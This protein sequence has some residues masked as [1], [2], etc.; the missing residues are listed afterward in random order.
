MTR[1][2]STNT[3]QENNTMKKYIVAAAAATALIAATAWA[4]NEA[5]TDKNAAVKELADLGAGVHKIK[6]DENNTLVSCVIVGQARISMS[7]GKAKGVMNAKKM[8]KQNAEAAFVGWL[9]K[10]VTDISQTGDTS[11]LHITGAD[12]NGEPIEDA[13]ST[14]TVSQI[15]TSQ[16]QGQI[17]AMQLIGMDQDGENNIMT[18]VVGWKPAFAAAAAGAAGANHTADATPGQAAP[19]GIDGA[20]GAGASGGSAANAGASG[21]GSSKPKVETKTRLS[22]EADDFL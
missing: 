2:T 22:K 9:K 8:A 21:S 16:A 20:A 7:L 17:R 13:Q 19:T 11:E 6:L 4:E 12:E 15:T 3:H 14:E 18:A 1:K 5:A 10:S